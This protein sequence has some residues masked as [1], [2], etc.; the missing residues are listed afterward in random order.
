MS[1]LNLIFIGPPGA[2]KGTQAEALVDEF[3]LA[4]LAT[5]DMM[6]AKRKEDS[7]LGR[8]IAQIIADGGLVD[9][10]IVCEVLIERI[11]AEGEDGFL[12]HGFD[13]TRTP[14]EVGDHIRRTVRTL[15][16]EEDL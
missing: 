14:D 9:D 6:R 8:K 1:A 10:D 13:G 12:L 2:G 5:G 16:R 3:D 15:R 7:E 11:D 4:Y